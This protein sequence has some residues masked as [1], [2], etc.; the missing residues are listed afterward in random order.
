METELS[1][2]SYVLVICTKGYCDKLDPKAKSGGKGVKWEGAIITQEIYDQ[3]GRN[4]R[5]IPVLFG[6]ENKDYIPR[7]LKAIHL[8]RCS[9]T[10][11][12]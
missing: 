3:E 1:S 2:S 10:S 11:R 8:L 5:F 4:K 6:E 9:S 7:P 12:L